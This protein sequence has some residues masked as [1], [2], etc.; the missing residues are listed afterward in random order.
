MFFIQS[1]KIV[2]I[3]YLEPEKVERIE[4]NDKLAY[5]T[6]KD[7]MKDIRTNKKTGEKIYRLQPCKC[8]KCR[9]NYRVVKSEKK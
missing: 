9:A 1:K 7:E 6:Y 3:R 2:K 4:F 8:K 5:F